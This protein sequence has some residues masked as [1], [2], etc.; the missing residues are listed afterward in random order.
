MIVNSLT[1]NLKSVVRS[2]RNG[3][4]TLGSKID[5]I[6]PDLIGLI[7]GFVFNTAR[8]V[9]SFLGENAWLLIMGFAVFVV[10]RLQKKR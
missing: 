2:D 1:R 10:E 7:A 5:G 6:L 8:S 3:C 4:K 9:I